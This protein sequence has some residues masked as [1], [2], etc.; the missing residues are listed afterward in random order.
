[1]SAVRTPL[2]LKQLIFNIAKK[3]DDLALQ[4]IKS[5]SDIDI[6]DSDNHPAAFE[7]A[8][9]NEHKAVNFLILNGASLINVIHGYAF[10]GNTAKVDEHIKNIKLGLGK[11]AYWA[12]MGGHFSYAEKIYLQDH[13]SLSYV[14]EAM[15]FSNKQSSDAEK[16]RI[17]VE[18]NDDVF[19]REV[20]KFFNGAQLVADA[21]E[22]HQLMK[23]YQLNY[24]QASA[25]HTPD[26]ATWFKGEISLASSIKNRK[27][28]PKDIFLNIARQIPQIELSQNE[29]NDLYDKIVLPIYKKPLVNKLKL[30]CYQ[31]TQYFYKRNKGYFL[32][33]TNE[34][35]EQLL[36]ACA[37]ENSRE[38][39]VNLLENEQ[40]QMTDNTDP[41]Y[42][43]LIEE[44]YKRLR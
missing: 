15:L 20:A 35:A 37:K 44:Q 42:R 38:Q 5:Y 29:I 33:S 21:K 19:R 2:E 24:Q 34:N 23:K 6:F 9:K 12:V 41:A 7:L 22:I 39:F 10:G 30:Y 14:K 13:R 32:F 28:I 31:Q 11:V 27:A 3:Q 17:L 18:L 26:F 36:K 43:E 16:L 40:K 8:A 25:L 1:M 4:E